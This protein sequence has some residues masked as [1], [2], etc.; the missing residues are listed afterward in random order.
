MIKY[1]RNEVVCN[2]TGNCIKNTDTTEALELSEKYYG[3]PYRVMIKYR[4]HYQ[5]F[6]RFGLTMEKD[7]GE[8][9]FRGSNPYGFDFY[10]GYLEVKSRFLNVYYW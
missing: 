7:A 8:N 2:L 10:S 9:F 4:Y 5:Q 6:I 1:G 3:A